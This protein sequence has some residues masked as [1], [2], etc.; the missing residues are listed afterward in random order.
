VQ[1][2]GHAIRAIRERTGL[3]ITDL[4]AAARIDRTNL[5]RIESGQRV[6]TDRQ[7]VDI[8]SALKVPLTAIINAPEPVA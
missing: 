8:A 7:L 5:S 3:S 2:N 1:A 4:A 6:G